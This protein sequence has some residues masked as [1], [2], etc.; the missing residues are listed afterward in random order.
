MEAEESPRNTNHDG[1]KRPFGKGGNELNAWTHGALL[2]GLC[3]SQWA[4]VKGHRATERLITG[5]LQSHPRT[6]RRAAEISPRQQKACV[7]R[8]PPRFPSGVEVALGYTSRPGSVR[9]LTSSGVTGPTSVLSRT[10]ISSPSAWAATAGEVLAVISRRAGVTPVGC[11][12]PRTHRDAAS[13]RIK[14]GAGAWL[15][16]PLRLPWRV[17]SCPRVPPPKAELDPARSD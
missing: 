13:G 10:S 9:R 5:S 16:V 4:L 1:E 7:P 3:G 6:R 17:S 11:P 14:P 2:S 12:S 8:R 15:S